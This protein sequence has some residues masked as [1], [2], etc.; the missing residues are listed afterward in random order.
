MIP[1]IYS[2]TNINVDNVNAMVVTQ[3]EWS[4]GTAPI[5]I[6]QVQVLMGKRE[7]HMTSMTIRI[8]K[9]IGM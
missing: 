2:E 6:F 9:T 4:I 1:K 7:V 5:D 8:T 3:A